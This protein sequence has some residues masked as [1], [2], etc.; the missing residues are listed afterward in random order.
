MRTIASRW[1]SAEE[2]YRERDDRTLRAEVDSNAYAHRRV[3]ILIDPGM[4]DSKTI[5]QIAL[6]ACNLTARWARNVTVVLPTNVPIHETLDRGRFTSLAERIQFEMREADPFGHFEIVEGDNYE[7]NPEAFPL[8]LFIGPWRVG[9]GSIQVEGDDYFVTAARAYAIGRRGRPEDS[10]LPSGALTASAALAASLGVADL[11][12]RAVGH[13]AEYWM[14]SFNWNLID[15]SMPSSIDQVTDVEEDLDI[16]NVLIAG[17]GAIGSSLVYLLDLAAANG[18]V[19]LLDRDIV[20]TSN[21]NR[22]LLFGVSDVLINAHKTELAER[23]LRS[24]QISA[25]C[26]NGTWREHAIGLSASDFDV[27]V[28]LTNEDGAWAQVPFQLPPVVLQG[29]TTSGWGFGAGRHIPRKEDCTLCRMPR[30]EAVFRGPCAEGEIPQTVATLPQRASLPF[31]SAASAALVLAELGKLR[32]QNVA[33]LP[34]DV[35]ADLKTGL[36]AVIATMRRPDDN[37]R[38]CRTLRSELW[39][40]RGGRGRY[41]MLSK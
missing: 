7:N 12:K 13:A 18:N 21:L 27:W 9:T 14:P 37:C 28:S 41:R 23:F 32:M 34:N 20:E 33:T 29:T 22:S 38:G 25:S 24:T 10:P 31:L 1:A 6:V 4:A 19:G 35:A 17:V 15:H 30:A 40:G 16:A 11:F 8:R 5:Q 26:L 36:P 3:E 39:D 2:F